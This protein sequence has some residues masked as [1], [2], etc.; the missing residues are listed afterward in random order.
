MT[1]ADK[2]QW[3]GGFLAFS[4]WPPKAYNFCLS[5][6][7]E[8]KNEKRLSDGDWG[9]RGYKAIGN[10]GDRAFKNKISRNLNFYN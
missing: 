10:M 3:D 2:N 4:R 9:N 5:C 8:Q 6:G 7:T 1:L